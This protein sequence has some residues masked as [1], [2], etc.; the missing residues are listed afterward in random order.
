MRVEAVVVRVV[1]RVVAVVAVLLLLVV[2][3]LALALALA[4]V[5]VVCGVGGVEGGAWTGVPHHNVRLC[6]AAERHTADCADNH[7][8]QHT[9][10]A[11]ASH[12]THSRTHVHSSCRKC[13][14]S[15]R[16]ELPLESAAS[17]WRNGCLV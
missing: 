8:H 15:H 17:E 13:E 6:M 16:C 14:A 2:L 1:V 10:T 9:S 4:V 7:T 11:C 3:A 12:A 5:V